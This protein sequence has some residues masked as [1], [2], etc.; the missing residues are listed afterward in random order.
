MGHMELA[1]STFT[2][3]TFYLPRH[4]VFNTDNTTTQLRVVFNGSA[5][6]TSGVSLNDILLKGLKVQP[7]I[8]QI[9]W[10]FRIHQVAITA[11]VVK[12]YRQVLVAP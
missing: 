10:Q 8:I 2:G 11:D 6:V 5:A 3:P 1:E 7:D 4:P 9:L 12:M